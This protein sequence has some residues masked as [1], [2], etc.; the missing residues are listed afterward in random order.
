M[1]SDLHR[2]EG[3]REGFAGFRGDKVPKWEALQGTAPWYFS[4][5]QGLGFI[6]YKDIGLRA[7]GL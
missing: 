7:Y 4:D 3:Q 1:L 6:N 2:L 5:P